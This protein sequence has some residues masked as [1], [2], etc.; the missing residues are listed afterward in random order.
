MFGK[1]CC[2]KVCLGGV[3]VKKCVPGAVF[4][5][6]GVCSGRDVCEQVCSGGVVVKKCGRGGVVV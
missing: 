3:A 1:H 5:K 6:I 4:C 2:E